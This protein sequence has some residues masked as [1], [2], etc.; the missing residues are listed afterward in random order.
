MI[1]NLPTE[2]LQC[3]L[4]AAVRPDWPWPESSMDLGDR[5]SMAPFLLSTICRL[6]RDILFNNSTVWQLVYLSGLMQHWRFDRAEAVMK[7][8]KENTL[9]L[10]IDASAA[11][12]A[13][14]PRFLNQLHSLFT[15]HRDLWSRIH[16]ILPAVAGRL[17]VGSLFHSQVV[18]PNLEE[19]MVLPTTGRRGKVSSITGVDIRTQALQLPSMPML[20]R[21]DVHALAVAPEQNARLSSLR[22]LSYNVTGT[23]ETLLWKTLE[24]C[25]N[26]VSLDIYFAAGPKQWTSQITILPTRPIYLSKVTQL[27]IFGFWNNSDWLHYINLPK[28]QTLTVSIESC[29]F[30]QPLFTKIS[31]QIQHLTLAR[32]DG[33]TYSMIGDTAQRYFRNLSAA[34]SR[35]SSVI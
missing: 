12:E 15:T 33:T 8:A 22:F 28:V 1:N 32:I 14:H 2:I 23:T 4:V 24:S 30:M 9:Q 29:N 11:A 13:E 34:R 16:I 18:L 5:L 3:I 25:P 27:A 6:W 21:W 20:R 35:R 26:L 7:R 19:L 17:F 10:V 31:G